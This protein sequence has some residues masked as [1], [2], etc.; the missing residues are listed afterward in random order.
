MRYGPKVHV[1]PAWQDNPYLNLLSLAPAAAGYQFI[2]RTTFDSLHETLKNLEENDT[3]HLHWTSPIAQSARSV[4]QADGRVAIVE[5]ELSKAKS[6]GAHVVWTIHNRL[7]HELLYAD[8]ERRLH[9]VL[10]DAADVIH[11]MSP[12]TAEIISDVVRL[13]S[14]KIVQIP[15]PSYAGVYDTDVSREEARASMELEDDDFAVLFLGQIRPYKGI[16]TLLEAASGIVRPDGRRVTLL[17]AGSASPEAVSQFDDLRP[18]GLRAVTAFNA[19]PDGDI[20]RW[21]RAADVAVFPYRA[22]LN[23]GSVHL[24]ATMNVPAI[25]PGLP[26]LRDQFGEQRWVK[27]FDLDRPVASLGEVLRAIDPSLVSTTDFEEFS[28][29]ISPWKV[30]QRYGAVLDQLS[31]S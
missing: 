11:V 5:K 16:D 1:F 27:F 7:P 20:A 10:A 18:S 8:A 3:I 29:G 26:H 6:R 4:R 2:G 12:A 30:S 25:L 9:Q 24:A 28:T 17:L 13:P 23:S 22:I 19:V 15:H 14:E 31:A 21:Y